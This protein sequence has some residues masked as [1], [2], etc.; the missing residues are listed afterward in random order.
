MQVNPIS[1]FLTVGFGLGWLKFNPGK[2]GEM[3][4]CNKDYK[5]KIPYCY[6]DVFLRC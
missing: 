6:L 1:H 2:K 5:V 4:A 3:R